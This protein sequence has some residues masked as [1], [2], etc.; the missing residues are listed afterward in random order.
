MS[1][2]I[3]STHG[4]PHPPPS[5]FEPIKND[6]ETSLRESLKKFLRSRILNADTKRATCVW[7]S[8]VVTM[9]TAVG[10]I[11]LSVLS[12]E[13][14]RKR[15]P[16]LSFLWLG[17]TIFLCSWN[18]LCLVIVSGVTLILIINLRHALVPLR[19]RSSAASIR[20][21]SS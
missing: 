10:L 3:S 16:N 2:F 6:V 18:G 12:D 7:I 4:Q 17:M 11:L 21:C 20:A 1:N 8:G 14:R 19:R 13:R 5:V 9:L 15:I